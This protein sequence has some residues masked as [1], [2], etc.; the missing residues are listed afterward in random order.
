MMKNKKI[1]GLIVLF[2]ITLSVSA[3]PS[4]VKGTL[5]NA[6]KYSSVYLFEYCGLDFYLTDSAKLNNG[7]FIFSPK[8][9]YTRGVYRIGPKKEL[10]FEIIYGK[11]DLEFAA[12]LNDLEKSFKIVKSDENKAY[13]DY[14]TFIKSVNEGSK[15]I[16][17]KANNFQNLAQSNPD[18]YKIEIAKLQKQMDSLNESI[19]EKY[20]IYARIYPNLYTGKL[21]KFLI[22]SEAI[23][24]TLL[25][26]SELAK[27]TAIPVKILTQYQKKFGNDIAKIKEGISLTLS[28]M[29]N[30][31]CLEAA[32]AGMV[33]YFVQ[34]DPTFSQ[35]MFD[36][37]E[38]IEEAKYK[39]EIKMMLPKRQPEVGEIAPDI[40]L[41]DTTGKMVSLSDYKGK[42]ILLDFW[43]SWCGPCRRENPNVVNIYNKYKDKGFFVFGVSLDNDGK[44][45]KEAIV[46][47]NLTW[48]HISDLKG[49]QSYAAQLYQVKG[50]PQTY[51]LDR[52]GKILAKNLRGVELELKL[53]SLFAGKN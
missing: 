33:A 38:E 7:V 28:K 31:I 35:A 19:N 16:Q 1:L 40:T 46:K 29:K 32:Y 11:E 24:E 49:W 13:Q 26:D 9:N 36:K 37:L 4:T 21:S 25:N 10:S 23:D 3:K 39:K 18:Q 15:T 51:L 41:A 43:A 30:P 50:I 5:K 20:K 17:G 34:P 22:S 8:K 45:W 6:E 44:R 52:D 48:A 14:M 42:V 47:D 12:D 2:F 53:E 27:G